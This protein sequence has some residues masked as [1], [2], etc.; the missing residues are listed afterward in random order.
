MPVV[1][2]E[3]NHF[4]LKKRMDIF[5][6]SAKVAPIVMKSDSTNTILIFVLGLLALMG[7]IFAL[8][9][10]FTSRDLRSMQA[11]A[12]TAQVTTQRINMLLGESLEY[13]KTHA[14]LGRILQ[15]FETKPAATR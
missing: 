9:V 7:V 3:I 4:S 11:Q 10:V 2:L 6:Q 5:G 15:S 13:S 1:F 8:Q 12:L 14:D